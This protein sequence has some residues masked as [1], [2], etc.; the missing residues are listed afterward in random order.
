MSAALT[1][2]ATYLP[3]VI[4]ASEAMATAITTHRSAWAAFQIAEGDE[5]W[6]QTCDEESDALFRLLATPADGIADVLALVA[7]LEWYA[8]EEARRYK[9]DGEL[10]DLPFVILAN[11]KVALR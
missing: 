10:N 7:H 2:H 4:G 8:E 5:A 6:W 9:R 3:A 1:N 11:L